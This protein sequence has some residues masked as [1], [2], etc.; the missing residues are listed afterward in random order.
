M[1]QDHSIPSRRRV[2]LAGAALPL[3]TLPGA[4][5]MATPAAPPAPVGTAAPAGLREARLLIEGR[6]GRLVLKPSPDGPL[7][8][9]QGAAADVTFLNAT[10]APVALDWLGLRG[11]PP[12]TEVLPLASATA[13]V[14]TVDA[15]TMAV[16]LSSPAL[17]RLTVPM[18]VHERQIPA[19]GPDLLVHLDAAPGVDGPVQASAVSLSTG[20]GA[21]IRLRLVNVSRAALLHARLEGAGVTLLA[22]DSQPSEPFPLA[23]GAL[24]LGAGQR[25]D[26][27]LLPGAMSAT[28]HLTRMTA[29]GAAGRATTR[30]DLPLQ[31]AG[32]H[33]RATVPALPSNPVEPRLDL[34]RATRVDLDIARPPPDDGPFA[35]IRRRGVLVIGLA[36]SGATIACAAIAGHTVRLLDGLDDGWKPFFLD[37]VLVA[38]GTVSRIAF[39]APQPGRFEVTMQ[40]V[41]GPDDEQR[42][43]FEVR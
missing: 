43:W 5:A 27:G 15:G 34:R 36:N 26:L 39:S 18:V 38:P 6:D 24:M 28:L 1:R 8:L 35:T 2:L 4:A 20:G 25:A 12:L 23:D 32:D 17:G 11:L 3:S 21:W 19:V 42:R 33:S 13:R 40:P 37:H 41:D 7:M 14:N 31:I 16:R 29:S 30:L 22:L 9:A 10:E